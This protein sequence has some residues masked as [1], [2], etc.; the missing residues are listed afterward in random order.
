VEE[1][2]GLWK[3]LSTSGQVLM[4]LGKY[5]FSQRY[6]WTADKYGLSWQIM[7]DDGHYQYK[8]RITPSLLFVGD[9]YGKAEEAMNFYTSIF[10]NGKVGDI[11][12]Y[13]AGMEPEKERTVMHGTFSLAEQE[14]FAMDSAR[15]HNF[16]FNEAISFIVN[17]EH[18]AEIDRYWEK[19]SAVPEAEQC[20][21]LKDKFG[22][23]W[24]IVSTDMGEM[25]QKGTPE[26]ID[27]VTQALLPMKKIIIADLEK[28][29]K[30][31]E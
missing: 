21:W 13:A 27:R 18:Q 10:P 4:E 25:L 3:K 2:D 16:E 12:R 20:G 31:G 28:A 17:C 14:F 9:V 7:F 6:G 19:L 30:G 5:P 26:Q 22:L 15:E 23:S 8:H 29:Y 1:V 11:A 24:Q